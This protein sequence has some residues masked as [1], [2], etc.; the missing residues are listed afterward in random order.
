[1]SK[2]PWLN[3]YYLGGNKV[4]L[5][6]QPRGVDIATRRARCRRSDPAGAC[7]LRSFPLS[8]SYAQ[9]PWL[10]M[11]IRGTVAQVAHRCIGVETF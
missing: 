7:L 10:L 11:V 9:T 8:N 2:E 3:S 1:M 5:A 6:S 4:G